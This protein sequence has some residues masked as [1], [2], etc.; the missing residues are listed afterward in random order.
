LPS[1]TENRMGDS[2]LPISDEQAKAFQE[3]LRTLQ[4][5]GGFLRD[6]LGTVPED[7]VGYFGGDAL[8]IRRAE[9]FV[10]I[11]QMARERMKA[12][13]AKVEEPASLALVLAI[14]VAAADESR[15]ELQD[16]WA[17]LLAAAADP[18][19]AKFFRLA[20]IEAAK[21]MD[22]ASSAPRTQWAIRRE[23]TAKN[24]WGTSRL[25]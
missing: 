10:R 13:G 9:N 4:G 20:F 7:L 21:K 2:L 17:R 16:L 22:P 12:R 18:A 23:R 15:D 11:V 5:V 6:I 3:A 25:A 14:A 24:Q 19:G 8:K 1:D